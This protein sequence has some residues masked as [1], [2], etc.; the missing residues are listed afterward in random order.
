MLSARASQDPYV[1]FDDTASGLPSLDDLL[2][3]SLLTPAVGARL[4]V[5]PRRLR[6]PSRRPRRRRGPPMKAPRRG[7]VYTATPDTL[8]RALAAAGVKPA[9]PGTGQPISVENYGRV[10]DGLR[11]DL[12]VAQVVCLGG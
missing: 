9:P 5:R 1:A 11:R 2:N 12:R 4:K 6:S 3:A 10:A 8:R 7:R